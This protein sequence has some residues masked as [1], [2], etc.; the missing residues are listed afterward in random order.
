MATAKKVTQL[1]EGAAVTSD[2]LLYFVD[3]PGETPTSK[4]ITVQNFLQSGAQ[5]NLVVNGTVVSTGL[6]VNGM[7]TPSNSTTVPA[8]KAAVGT[9]WFDASYIYVV[10]ATGV[11]KRAALSSF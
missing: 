3:D 7:V 10:T 9:L 2:D 11:I 1:T 6:N 4:K 5:S 8:G